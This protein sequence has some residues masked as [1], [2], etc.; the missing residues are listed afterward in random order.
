MREKL[1]SSTPPPSSDSLPELNFTKIE[2][3]SFS[4]IVNMITYRSGRFLANNWIATPRLITS[5][6]GYD[7]EYVTNNPFTANVNVIRKAPDFFIAGD[8]NGRLAT[9]PN[10]FSWTLQD[11]TSGSVVSIRYENSLFVS[12][13]QP[14]LIRTSSNGT[15]WNTRYNYA[16]TGGDVAN[17]ICYNPTTGYWHTLS[18]TSHRN[19]S[20]PDGIVWS[21]STDSTLPYGNSTSQGSGVNYLNGFYYRSF[22]PNDVTPLPSYILF[23]SSD[24]LEWEEVKFEGE[25]VTGTLRNTDSS[26]YLVIGNG[27]MLILSNDGINFKSYDTKLNAIALTVCITDNQVVVCSS[28]G[29]SIANY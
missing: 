5:T 17:S 11:S 7:W 12:A 1:I 8:A 10:G 20:S 27:N 24:L 19:R 6:N 13:R 2:G 26:D 3:L 22:R 18:T 21:A 29:L 4:P 14:F 9:S 23:K 16:A 28:D 25:V 15:N